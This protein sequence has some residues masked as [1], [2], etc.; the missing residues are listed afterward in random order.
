MTGNEL[1]AYR[2][3]LGLTQKAFADQ[4]GYAREHSIM[5]MEK[6]RRAVPDQLEK[7]IGFFKLSLCLINKINEKD[8]KPEL[9]S[10]ND[11]DIHSAAGTEFCASCGSIINLN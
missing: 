2:L 6:G 7:S 3:S 11:P 10:C 5:D 4:F 1:K 9:C 8:M